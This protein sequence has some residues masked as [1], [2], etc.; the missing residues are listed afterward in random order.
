MRNAFIAALVSTSAFAS[1]LV[2]TY[3]MADTNGAVGSAAG[4]V[5]IDARLVPGVGG[6]SMGV[7]ALVGLSDDVEFGVGG[8]TGLDYRAGVNAGVLAPWVRARFLKHGETHLSFLAGPVIDFAVR[9]RS[10]AGSEVLFTQGFGFGSL[11][12]NVGVAASFGT[13]QPIG[14]VGAGLTVNLPALL[15]LYVEVFGYLTSGEGTLGER[16]GLAWAPSQKFAVDV[17]A[18]VIEAPASTTPVSVFP[19]VGATFFL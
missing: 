5:T 19:Q 14:H 3:G 16:A 13:G 2:G 9:A 18:G 4:A 7:S 10:L 15:K 12:A 6:L 17:S 8:A 1:N 11:D